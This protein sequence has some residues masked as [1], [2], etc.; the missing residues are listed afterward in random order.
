[1]GQESHTELMVGSHISIVSPLYSLILLGF[2]SF[3]GAGGGGGQTKGE[4][5]KK[6]YLSTTY[7]CTIHVNIQF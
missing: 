7:K 6:T 1:M 5:T 4:A 3:E 2:L